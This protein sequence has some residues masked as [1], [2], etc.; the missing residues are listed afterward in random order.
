M[1]EVDDQ[2]KLGQR[3][4][5]KKTTIRRWLG[6]DTLTCLRV[7]GETQFS[8]FFRVNLWGSALD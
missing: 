5:K 2:Q 1:A 4:E 8:V 3:A 7:F 6:I